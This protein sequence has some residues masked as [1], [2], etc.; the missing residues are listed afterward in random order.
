MS[1]THPNAELIRRFYAAFGQRDAEAM[2]ACYADDVQFGDPAFPDLKGAAAG[3]M[4]RMLCES[5]RDLRIEAS[6]VEADDTQARARWVAHYTFSATGRP[7][8]ND[9]R[10]SFRL[11][12]GRIVEH[13]D[14]FDFARWARQALGL[15]GLLL[16]WTGWLQRQVQAKAARGLAGFQKKRAA[17]A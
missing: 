16:G 15:P 11:R 12:D 14:V 3:D 7:V 4:W 1:P 9:I 10:A 13:R 8:V 2:A 5:A 6:E 17:G